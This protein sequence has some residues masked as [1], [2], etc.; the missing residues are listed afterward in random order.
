MRSLGRRRKRSK[1]AERRKFGTRPRTADHDHDRADT[2]SS[3][4]RYS[5]WEESI[6]DKSR[7]RRR[8][9]SR[10][11]ERIISFTRRLAEKQQPPGEKIEI[12]RSFSIAIYLKSSD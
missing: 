10:G 3:V 4:K 12:P 6:A 2:G 1:R 9:L 7:K 8:S 11:K 5:D